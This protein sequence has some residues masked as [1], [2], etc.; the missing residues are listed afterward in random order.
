MNA[1]AFI[2]AAGFGTRLRP[3]TLD[4]PKPLVPVAGRP[5][6]DQALTLCRNAGIQEVVINAHH[7]AEAVVEY[8]RQQQDLAI[9]VQ[10]E[11]PDILGTGGGLKAASQKLS[12]RF[13]VLNG[14]I[15]CDAPVRELLSELDPQCEAVMLLR[16]ADEAKR[17]G[18]VAA[19]AS[20]RVV[21][22]VSLARAEADGQIDNSTHFTGLH[23]L[24]QSALR[25]VPEGFACIVR[26]AYCALVPNRAVGSVLLQGDWFDIGNP[27]DY[28]EA[29]LAVL[30]GEL[31]LPLDT[32]PLAS[33]V[34]AAG[35]SRGRWHGPLWVGQ[36][37]QI[38]PTA[39][40]GPDVVLGDGATIGANVKLEQT[41]VWDGATV[42]AN[43]NLCRA[44]VHDSGSLNVQG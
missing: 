39:V 4:R 38:D 25:H 34:L 19:D 23:A 18:V 6:L 29:N 5:V 14:D 7:L 3:L 22:L 40:L 11:R 35:E 8:G 10:I 13:I 1:E 16:R 24:S 33:V 32:K 20:G 41:V 2:L 37:T 43:A 36:N 27:T 9:H 30:R 15:L 17:F 21:D 28:L 42:P 44:V 12:D 31:R 26:S